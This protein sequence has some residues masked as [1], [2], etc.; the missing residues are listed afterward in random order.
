MSG[1]WRSRLIL[2]AL[3]GIP[4]NDRRSA[5]APR[6]PF[7]TRFPETN[8]NTLDTHLEPPFAVNSLQPDERRFGK[9]HDYLSGLDRKPSTNAHLWRDADGKALG[10]YFNST[11]TSVFQPIRTL[12]T[13]EIAGFQGYLRSHSETDSGLSL[14]RLL[15]YA[16]SD[17]ESIELDRL[18]RLLH[19]LNFFRQT[20]ATGRDLY[21]NVHARLLAAVEDNHGHAFRR[22][23]ASIDVPHQRVVLQLPAITQNLSW[24]LDSVVTNYRGNGFRI[25]VNSSRAKEALGLL[26]RVQ[27]DVVKL[28]VRGVTD[29]A[30][31]EKLL[32]LA[33]QRG[34]QVIF[35]R[36]DSQH[37]LSGLRQFGHALG[38]T[39]L[40]QGHLWDVPESALANVP[41]SFLATTPLAA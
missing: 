37:L 32:R 10:R 4:A 7:L 16:A 17:D 31:T 29:A 23:L 22:V 8:M 34:V 30:S 6:L 21:L 28:D 2:F 40:V 38:Q 3:A 20:E 18:C 25:A 41:S 24:L 15:D 36:V 19:T 26:E 39:L 33:Q 9:L 14:W 5:L 27:P 35:K 13:G 11:L 1:V 12:D